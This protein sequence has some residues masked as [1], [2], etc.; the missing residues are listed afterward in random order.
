MIVNAS[1]RTDIPAFYMEW[2]CNRLQAGFFDV[3][4][5]FAPKQ[6]SR[7]FLENIDA[8]MFCTKNPIPL[9]AHLREIDKPV[10]LD[11]TI[12]PYHA[13]LEPSVPD[14]KKIIAAVREASAILGSAQISVRYDPILFNARYTVDY[15]LRAFE[16]LCGQLEGYVDSI[17]ISFLD[18]YKNVRRHQKELGYHMPTQHELEKLGK[19]FAKSA[20]KHSIHVFTCHE[21]DILAP[22]GIPA[23]AC[24]SQKQAYQMTGRVFKQWKARECGCVEMADVGAYNSCLHLCKYCYANFDESRIRENRAQHDPHSSLLIGHL[25][26]GDIVKR[27]S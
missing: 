14:K 22:Y 7:I 8:F 15:H 10:L 24:F 16:V 26:P 1:G 23:D 17:S 20:K 27:R 21:Q 3:R 9:V 13:D 4:N 18:E 19:G 12:T 25:E 6:V 2:F 11:V 5:P